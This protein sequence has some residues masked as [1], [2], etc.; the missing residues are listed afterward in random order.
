VRRPARR[1][2]HVN[3]VR[4]WPNEALFTR[5][6]KDDQE[7][8]GNESA[9]LCEEE[10]P[11]GG[12]SVRDG[13]STTKWKT[14]RASMDYRL[15]V[16]EAGSRTARWRPRGTWLSVRRSWKR[17]KCGGFRGTRQSVV[18]RECCYRRSGGGGARRRDTGDGRVRANEA[19][20]SAAKRRGGS[21][22]RRCIEI[23]WGGGVWLEEG[24][25]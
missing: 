19:E 11:D 15:A 8:G 5:N 2:S 6:L 7:A 4:S 25:R 12:L 22:I 13:V 3:A 10:D 17:L 23:G 24:V 9:R 1:W 18:A 16:R 21:G 14:A 20:T